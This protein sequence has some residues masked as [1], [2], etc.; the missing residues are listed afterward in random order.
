MIVVGVSW[1][2]FWALADVFKVEV[3][4]AALVTGVVFVL[5]GLVLGERPVI[6]Q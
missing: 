4:L 1:V 3:L 5:L 2:L 6:K